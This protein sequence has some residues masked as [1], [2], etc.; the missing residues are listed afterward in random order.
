MTFK[1]RTRNK[2]YPAES[3]KDEELSICSVLEEKT[4]TFIPKGSANSQAFI[5]VFKRRKRSG[6]KESRS[7]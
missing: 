3:G 5:E 6:T 2:I 7:M 4:A 1:S